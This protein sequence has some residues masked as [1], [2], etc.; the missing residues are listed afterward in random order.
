MLASLLLVG[1]YSDAVAVRFH[2]RA[3]HPDRSNHGEGALDSLAQHLGVATH[4]SPMKGAFTSSK[5]EY[6]PLTRF[7]G[8]AVSAVEHAK[9]VIDVLER[10]AEKNP[11]MIALRAPEQ[12]EHGN[13]VKKS[14]FHRHHDYLYTKYTWKEYRDLVM[15]AATAFLSMGLQPLDAVNIRGI[16]SPE[17][18][19][20]FLGCI[21]AGGLPVGLYPTD[22][23]DILEFKAK[24]SGAAFI[25]LGRAK[26][27]AVYSKFLNKA[28]FSGIKAVIMWDSNA[29]HPEKLNHDILGEIGTL[30][31]PLLGWKAFLARGQDRTA[32]NFRRQLR[33]RLESQVPGQAG[34]VVYTSG[35]TGNPKGVMLS[36]DALTWSAETLANKVL[37]KSPPGGQ[38]RIISY[39]PLNHVA[40]QMLDIIAPLVMSSLETGM[41]TTVYFPA[42]CYV[43]KRCFKEQLVDAKPTLF[44]GVPEVWDGLKLKIEEATKSKIGGFTKDAFPKVVL[45]K[46]GLGSTMYAI[47]GAGPLS[48]STLSFFHG[49]G[50]NIL[51]MYA[52]SESSALGTSW[53]KADFDDFKGGDKFGSIGRAVGNRLQIATPDG[54]GKGEIQLWG[55]N[56]MLGYLNRADKTEEAISPEGWLSTGDLGRID[57]DGFVFLTGRLKEIMKDRGGEMIAPVAVEEG[58][59]KA[60]NKPER[61]ILKQAI[62]VG[63]GKYYISA[64]LTLVESA[65]DGIPTGDLTGAARQVDPQA[66]TVEQAKASQIWASMLSTCIAEYNEEAAKSQQRVYRFLVLPKDITAEDSPDLMTP[67]FKIKRSGVTARYAEEIKSCGGDEALRDRSVRPCSSL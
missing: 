25:V 32:A 41:Y 28:E 40:G 55:R 50:L 16:N 1:L 22:S 31:R 37:V 57:R 11:N 61:T 2:S 3:D 56:V 49:M 43:K 6:D 36:Q 26:D 30:S 48:K 46:V 18:L 23:D 24:D 14:F 59:K 21:A 44:L 53:L 39:L 62:V 12:D 47:S 52:Q 5:Y 60:C 38:M 58:I 15:D 34:T 35:T 10:A 19:I 33:E 29:Q 67:T 17:W 64:L 63:D 7:A 42:A 4:L 8:D 66:T 13:L 9:L 27:L 51:N 65:D 54:E 20:T 45:G